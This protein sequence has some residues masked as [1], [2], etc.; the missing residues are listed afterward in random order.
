MKRALISVC[1]LLI[2]GLLSC[3]KAPVSHLPVIV[4]ET[5]TPSKSP[6]VRVLILDTKEKISVEVGSANV[7]CRQN[8]GTITDGYY[9]KG[10]M[11]VSRSGERLRVSKR[12]GGFPETPIL[13]VRPED[14][15]GFKINGKRYRGTLMLQRG[16]GNRILA[17]NIVEIDDYLKGVL[18]SEIGYLK[19]EQN[20]AFLVQAIASRSYA[21][22]K[23]DE[24]KGEP[25]DL[26]S[27]IMDQVYRGIDGEHPG[28]SRAV[29]ESR[30]V[31]AL[32]NGNP[33]KAYYSSCC[34]GYTADIRVGWP[35]KADFP[36]LYGGRDA[37][38]AKA[39]TFC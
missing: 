5:P 28:A 31:V 8:E 21:L 33:I 36:Y 7:A 3:G 23:L 14:S 1:S 25:Y 35:W 9:L 26:R 27:T 38:A 32:W 19:K 20:E 6:V 17:I 13:I 24:K 34:G 4:D 16:N 11:A 30:G 12:G 15:G 2:L 10:A 37:E 29:E 18:P 22:S 39:V